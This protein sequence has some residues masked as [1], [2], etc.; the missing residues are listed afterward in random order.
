MR[1]SDEWRPLSI[2]ELQRQL[3]AFTDW[4]LCG[5]CSVDLFL[6]RPTR[7]HGD[8]DIGVF[9]S[10]LVDCLR[11]VGR[12]QVYLCSAPRTYTRWDGTEIDPAVHDIW[13]SDSSGGCWILQIVVFDDEGDRVFYR[14]N[15]R[16]HWSKRSHAIR[17]GEF[18]ILNPY[19][20]FLYKA[21]KADMDEK[22][23]IDVIALIE[24][25]A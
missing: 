25:V 14:R 23:V 4:V 12:D 3:G 1:H 15:R 17:C 10:G 11:A 6:G 2:D 22:E 20:T 16:I 8:V 18:R 24:T 19:I 7:H 21:A 5:G 9:R 13:I